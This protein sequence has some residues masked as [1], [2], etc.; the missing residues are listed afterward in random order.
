MSSF[1]GGQH[2]DFAEVA[3]CAGI[4]MSWL[5][6]IDEACDAFFARRGMEP[7]ASWR[8]QITIDCVAHKARRASQFVSSVKSVV[9]K[10]I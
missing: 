1:L 4:P 6:E 3:L 10:K 2:G 7:E 9:P 8:E 5:R